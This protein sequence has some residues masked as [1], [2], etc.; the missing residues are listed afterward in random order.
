MKRVTILVLVA[1][2]NDPEA[3]KELANMLESIKEMKYWSIDKIVQAE[4]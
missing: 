2:K 3:E 4:T 1:S